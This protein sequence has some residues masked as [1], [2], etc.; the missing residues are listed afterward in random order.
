MG[1]TLFFTLAKV[2]LIKREHDTISSMF[3][4]KSIKLDCGLS[5]LIVPMST[6]KSLTSLL[7]VNTGSRYE[8]PSEYGMAHLLEHLVFRGTDQF[9][10]SM[11]LSVAL[12]GI[13]A[14]SNAFTAKE[15]TGFYVTAAST[16]LEFTLKVL[17]EL[18]MKPLLKRPDL[19][20]EKKVV[21]EEI[22]MH[23]DSPEEFL[24]DAFEQMVY[25]HSSLAHPICGN[26]TSVR[27]LTI[28]GMQRFLRRWYSL[29]NL[30]LVLAGDQQILADPKIQQVVENVFAKEE[31]RTF[32]PSDFEFY[33]EDV[34]PSPAHQQWRERYLS[35]NP[36]SSKQ[37]FV[38]NKKVEQTYVTLG[39]P[40]LKRGDKR[41][42]ALSLLSIILGGNRSSRLFQLV[43]EEANLAYYVYADLDQYHDG[44]LLGVS[45]GLNK[46]LANKGI[47]LIM[48]ECEAL[49]THRKPIKE[50]ELQRA[51]DYLIGRIMLGLE[52]S[53][54]VAQHYGLSQ[55][56]LGEYESPQQIIDG[57]NG[58]KIAEI[59]EL[60]EQIIKPDDVRLGRVD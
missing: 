34:A 12:D 29:S 49:A 18:V 46:R 27:S 59:A 2:L 31:E 33:A 44:G 38:H 23:R 41:R 13:G 15:Y 53:R 11:S 9:P 1:L 47:K 40:A 26:A 14:S 7:L 55:L 19:I 10:D 57:L 8:Q 48:D 51:K 35:K 22:K 32:L 30:S 5:L 21:I 25:K 50:Q 58:V 6:V 16:H 56:L 37:L 4:V 42:H 60:A 54:S 24:A 17:K 20:Q 39:W 36:I 28:E 3:A 45:A 52:S 43:R